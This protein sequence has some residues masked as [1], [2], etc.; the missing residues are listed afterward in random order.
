MVRKRTRRLV[1][2]SVI[3]A[4]VVAFTSQTGAVATVHR[5]G[6]TASD[7]GVTPTSITLGNIVTLTGPIPGLFKGSAA[8]TDAYFQYIN[9][10]HGVNGRKLIMKGGD[11][12]LNCNQNQTQT[13]DMI[14]SV[15]AFVGSFAVF[16]NCGA[17]VFA[18]NPTV[19]D[20][21]YLLSDDAN[22]EVNGFSPQPAPPGFRTGPYQYYKQKYPNAVTKVGSLW[23]TTS[24]TT[25]TNQKAAEESLGFKILYERGTA[26]TETDWTADIIRMKNLGVEF[27][28][29]RNQN[30]SFI[31]K[32]LSEAQQQNFHPQV[33]I[34]NSEYDANFFKLI[35]DPTA[36]NG[37][38]TDQP[39]A[40][41]LGEDAKT[42]PEVA[43][44]LKW[45]KKSHPDVAVDL[46]AM[47]SWASAALFVDALK[48]AG[49][50][51]TRAGLIAALKNIHNFDDNGFVAPAD[52]GNKKP[53]ACY[54]ILQVN[55]GKFHRVVPKGKGYICKPTGYYLAQS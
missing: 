33:I 41:F 29:L 47:Y 14:G 30:A 22:K 54:L 48:A 53:P 16:D 21:H 6:N 38:L 46:F 2:I 23:A 11:D 40:M 36:A 26:P 52:V 3:V 19:A 37:V 9:S 18:Q 50:N 1:G 17:K 49:Q 8:G 13:Q 43:L 28:D 55:N 35:A 44:F 45:M 7:V 4:L 10:K 42:T 12:A 20:I 31:A 15:F 27:W 51:P 25:W 24:P 5:A 32:M 39:F 34:T